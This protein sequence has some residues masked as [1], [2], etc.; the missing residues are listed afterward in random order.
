MQSVR[1]EATWERW[2]EV[3]AWCDEMAPGWWFSLDEHRGSNRPIRDQLTD[4]RKRTRSGHSSAG[5]TISFKTRD[6]FLMFKLTWIG[7]E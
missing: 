4:E 1:F 7:V 3:I 2:D 6:H 5:A